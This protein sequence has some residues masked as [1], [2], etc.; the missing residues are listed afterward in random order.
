MATIIKF[1][2]DTSINWSSANPILKDGEPGLETDTG[3]IKYG[4]GVTSWNNLNYGTSDSFKR[5][6]RTPVVQNPN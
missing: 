1:K 5:M 2:R 4:D 3:K 6:Y